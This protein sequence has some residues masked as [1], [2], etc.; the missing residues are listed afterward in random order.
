MM[1]RRA[2]FGNGV[3]LALFLLAGGM[4]A[5][6]TR[7]EL[8]V[9]FIQYHYYNGFAFLKDRLGTDIAPA[10]VFSQSWGRMQTLTSIRFY[11]I[12]FL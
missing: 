7:Y 3:V 2:V 6:L 1:N 8:V 5:C 11:R 9:D 4:A 12:V 10:P